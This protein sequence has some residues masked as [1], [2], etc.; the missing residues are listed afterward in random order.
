[1]DYA[2][3]IFKR[4]PTQKER[5]FDPKNYSSDYD[6]KTIHKLLKKI[7]PDAKVAATEKI[8][9][10]LAY[11]KSIYIFPY[12]EDADYV[13]LLLN[14]STYPISKKKFEEEKEI[15]LSNDKWRI[16]VDYYPLLIL[17]RK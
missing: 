13:I 5:F 10:H 16:A 9:P 7:P 14:S 8:V 17:E 6:V 4:H 3:R 11:R 15:Y 1:M 2:N 12:Y